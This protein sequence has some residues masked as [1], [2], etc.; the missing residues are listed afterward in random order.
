MRITGGELLNRRLEVPR[1]DLRPSQD[2]VR[3]AMFSSIA[4]LVP[5]CRFLDLF[6]GT[7]SVGLEAWSRG[8]A[9]VCWVESARP[10][11]AALRKNVGQL[12]GDAQVEEVKIVEDD[13]IA[14]LARDSVLQFDIIFADPPYDRDGSGQWLKKTLL[15]LEPGS[16]LAPDGLFLFERAANEPEYDGDKWVMTGSKV[17]GETRLDFFVRMSR[18]ES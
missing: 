17:Y 11:L 10:V 12:C 4:T 1:T 18:N 15:A 2:R 7:G 8:A 9:S 13:A 6:A 14:F 3:E 16:M 5:G